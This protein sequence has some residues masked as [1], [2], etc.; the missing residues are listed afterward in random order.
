MVFDGHGQSGSA[1]H[2]LQHLSERRTPFGSLARES[3]GDELHRFSL[4]RSIDQ[5]VEAKVLIHSFDLDRF[6]AAANDGIAVAE[7]GV[8]AGHGAFAEL[9]YRRVGLGLSLVVIAAVIVALTLK[10]R[11]IE[12]PAPP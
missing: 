10:V 4:Q 1:V 7:A 5:L 12:R 3:L 6:Q 2:K 11:E 8:A 9:R